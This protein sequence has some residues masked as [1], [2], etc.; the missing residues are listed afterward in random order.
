MTRMVPCLN[1]SQISREFGVPLREV[2]KAVWRGELRSILKYPTEVGQYAIPRQ[3]V[4]R[5]LR[6]HPEVPRKEQAA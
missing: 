1:K 3:H 6:E 4:L 2:D 5:W